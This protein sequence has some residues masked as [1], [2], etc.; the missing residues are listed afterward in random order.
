MRTLT[1]IFALALLV[2][3]CTRTN[4]HTSEESAGGLRLV[5]TIPLPNVEGRIDHLDVDVKGQRLLVAA[6][7]NNTV[8]VVDLQR[9]ARTQS[10]RGFNEPQG[11]RYLPASNTLVVANG[12]DGV[13][14]F[15]DAASFKQVK[16]ARFGGDADN[17]RYDA[18]HNRIYVGYGGGALAVL[19]EK[20]ERLGDIPLG[21]H[22][23]SFQLDSTSGRAYINVPARQEIAVVDLNKMTVLARWPVQVASANYP[24]ALDGE[25]HRLFVMTRKPAHLLVYDTEAG[26]LVSTLKA[27]AD[28]DDVFYDGG[29]QRIY[30]S[31]GEGTVMVY[32]Q[33]DA[34]HYQ[35]IATV[36]TAA[37]ARTSFFSPELR[38]LYVAV[39][40][41][42]TP[43]AE[44]RVYQ[45]EP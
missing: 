7:G 3:A 42:N 44:I 38:Q 27:G 30:A 14:S 34:D 5:R 23:E 9:G 20:G 18:A 24:M 25:H 4:S 36:A 8:E 6:L 41:R 19:D 26:K 22:P 31:F 35:V 15:W 12:G 29:R 43:T 16:T 21:G 2:A 45:V 33:Q 28:S 17:V 37:G 32:E 11:I 39:P 40:H 13:I 1:L 10:L